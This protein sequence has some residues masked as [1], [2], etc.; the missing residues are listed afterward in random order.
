[1]I[2]YGIVIQLD[3]SMETVLDEVRGHLE[4]GGF[5]VLTTI[6]VKQKLKEKLDVD[7]RKYMILGAC[8]PRMAHQALRTEENIG[9]MLPCNV[10]VYEQ[11]GKTVVAAIR[12]TVA[13]QMIDN[14]ELRAIAEQVEQSLRKVIESLAP[15]RSMP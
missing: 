10:I 11:G 6:D 15:V 3:S 13:M 5:G 7:F 2:D 4:N 1:M 9:L 12:P 14:P 8:N